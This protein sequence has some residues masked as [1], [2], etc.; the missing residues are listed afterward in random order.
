MILEAAPLIDESPPEPAAT[1]ARPTLLVVDDDRD[2]SALIRA[3]CEARGF[4]VINASDAAEGLE[5]A[6]TQGV[7]AIVTD[8]QMPGMDGLQ[9]CRALR[10]EGERSASVPPIWIMSGSVALTEDEARRAGARAL[11]RKPFR[12]AD[13][14]AQIGA[15]L[16]NHHSG[17][18]GR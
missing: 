2:F 3:M 17:A 4:D 1:L 7:D 18:R 6:R 12:V 11:F 9:F 14:T 15:Y 10:T 16:K 8:Y 13:I 5:L